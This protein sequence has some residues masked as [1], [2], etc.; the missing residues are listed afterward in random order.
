M[1][2]PA[3]HGATSNT[4]IRWI[5]LALMLL[6]SFVSY[7]LRTNMSIVS[8][9]VISDLGL[10]EVHLGMV[11]SAFAAGY[12]IFQFPGG[13]FGDR[14]GSRFSIAA[15]AVAWG[16]LT[17][18]TGL[19]PGSGVLSVG[20]VVAGLIAVR[21]LVG[22]THAPIFPVLGGTVANWFPVGGWGLP[23]GLGSTGLTLGAAATAP[24]V[25]WLMEIYG[26]RGS[27]FLTA[28]AAFI[29]A[30]IWWWYVRDYPKDHSKVGPGEL[31][32]IDA[33]RPPPHSASEERGVWKKVLVNRNILLLTASYFCMNYVFYLFFNWFF[34]YLV[35]VKEFGASEAGA[36]TAAQWIIGA[37]GAT[38][39]GFG[40]DHLIRRFGLR[41]G[42]QVLTIASLISC[43]IFLFL[44]A[45][46]DQPY[47]TVILLCICFGCTQIT[48]AAYWSTATSVA[49]RHT[50]VA[51]GVLNTGGNVVGFV[52]SM[53]V[54]LT[55]I[56]FGWVTAISMGSVFALIGAV[57]W[58]FIHGDEPMAEA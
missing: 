51:C 8:A 22:V 7:L 49:R 14:F 3:A 27:F 21:F 43:A 2:A 31:A 36:L 40:C 53:L 34:F 26:W 25:V 41:R 20:A 37:V 10:S 19:V 28:P 57:L 46:S 45:T 15:I 48:E 18:A 42:P 4:K 11:F 30:G 55:A 47:L 39:G 12:A 29:T 23:N 58:L 56:R 38:L 52:G 9:A 35:D 16:V 17:I 6:A 33:G 50:A 5:I 44:G 13:L 24:L 1:N 32:L 54:P